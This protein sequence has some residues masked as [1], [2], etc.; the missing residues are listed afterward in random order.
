MM[1]DHKPVIG[2]FYCQLI[3]NN[4]GFLKEMELKPEI[5][6]IDFKFAE[7]CLNI[8][9]YFQALSEYF[10]RLSQDPQLYLRFLGNDFIYNGEV[11]SSGTIFPSKA[12]PNTSD[13]VFNYRDDD[14]PS[15]YCIYPEIEA[16]SYLS[17]AI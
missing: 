4:I 11:T 17:L 5:Y 6:R 12:D 14:I 9:P 3:Y 8:N 15:L 16:Y 13:F 7:L 10:P 1:S 2:V